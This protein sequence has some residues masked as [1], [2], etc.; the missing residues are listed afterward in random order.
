MPVS[1]SSIKDHISH[2]A[3]STCARLRARALHAVAA[4]AARR[5]ARRWLQNG[6]AAVWPCGRVA[7]WWRGG[8][9]GGLRGTLPRGRGTSWPRC[10]AA[11]VAGP[12]PSEAG[13]LVMF[14]L[15]RTPARCHEAAVAGAPSSAAQGWAAGRTRRFQPV[16]AAHAL[17]AALPSPA[18]P[19]PYRRPAPAAHLPL[20]HTCPYRCPDLPGAASCR[21]GPTQG[22][23]PLFLSKCRNMST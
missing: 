4:R 22:G 3:S 9:A 19:L 13:W 2:P 11:V 5:F 10:H 21:L 23:A 18:L 15:T 20:P 8:V 16:A 1:S 12:L 17:P 7:A 6:G 14:S